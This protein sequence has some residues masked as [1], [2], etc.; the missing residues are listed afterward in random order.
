M[1]F[2]LLIAW[3][4]MGLHGWTMVHPSGLAVTPVTHEQGE[5]GSFDERRVGLDH[6]AFHIGD[7]A[8]LEAW[9]KHVDEFGVA[10][11]GIQD[12]DGGRGGPLIVLRDPDNI[13]IELTAGWQ[14]PEGA[15]PSTERPH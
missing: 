8:V 2:K 10:H 14:P 6:V 13:Q 7:L 4:H 5:I 15:E 9:A 1:D 3:E 12:H 11:S